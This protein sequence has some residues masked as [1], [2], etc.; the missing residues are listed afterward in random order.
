M[1]KKMIN[2]VLHGDATVSRWC[3]VSWIVHLKPYLESEEICKVTYE[4]MLDNPQKEWEKILSFLGIQRSTSEIETAIENQSFATAKKKFKEIK[5]A[6][7]ASFLRKGEQGY[8]VKNFYK[9]EKHIFAAEIGQE[10]QYLGY[11]VDL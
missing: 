6:Y 11:P 2:T 3:K 9:K 4:S 5:D 1:K 8:W 7:K 10:L